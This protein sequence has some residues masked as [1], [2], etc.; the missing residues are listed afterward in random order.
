MLETV[1]ALFLR[2]DGRVLLGLR[3]SWKRAWADHW[4]R[5]AAGSRRARRWMTRLSANAER[6]SVWRRCP[7]G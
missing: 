3:A 4:T 1:S 2:A 7:I 6:R 5:S